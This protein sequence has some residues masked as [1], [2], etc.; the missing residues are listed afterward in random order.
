M[1]SFSMGL[2]QF[3]AQEN[4]NEINEI[5]D[6]QDSEDVV[7]SEIDLQSYIESRLQQDIGNR[8]IVKDNHEEPVIEPEPEQAEETELDL[9]DVSDY[10]NSISKDEQAVCVELYVRLKPILPKSITITL[11]NVLFVEDEQADTDVIQSELNELGLKVSVTEHKIKHIT[12]CIRVDFE[13]D[14][15]DKDTADID[16]VKRVMDKYGYKFQSKRKNSLYF[17]E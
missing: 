3:I 5:K 17:V 9:I 14:L 11:D 8:V 12:P 2:A 16:K 1:G 15:T 13:S 7:D 6:V 4:Q 10:F